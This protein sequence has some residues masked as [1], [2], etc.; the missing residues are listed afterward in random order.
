MK[1]DIYKS[2]EKL[3]DNLDV[4]EVVLYD[5]VSTIIKLSDLIKFIT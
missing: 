3:E 5:R 2:Y 1:T 4:N